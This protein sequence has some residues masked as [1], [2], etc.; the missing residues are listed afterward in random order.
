MVISFS[1]KFQDM[2]FIEMPKQRAPLAL[3]EDDSL[4][5]PIRPTSGPEFD[6]LNPK[7]GFSEADDMV[8]RPKEPSD[9][10]IDDGFLPEGNFPNPEEPIIPG[11]DKK[12]P[13]LNV[14]Q[15]K[16]T[17][18]QGMMDLALL[19][20]NANQLRYILEAGKEHS[21]FYSSLFFVVTSI[22]LQISVGILLLWNSRFNIKKEHH[23]IKANRIN[24]ITV[25][26]IF[27]ITIL[28]V[29]IS[30]FGLPENIPQKVH[31]T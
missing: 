22:T 15:Q 28:N 1:W 14:Y 19:S 23:I 16:K 8:P 25:T 13:D 4:I 6:D 9:S 30:A 29:F 27:L 20:A 31:P 17:F 10:G 21:Y 3:R 5:P 12:L 24:N 18:A 7:N 2:E 11:I 26:G